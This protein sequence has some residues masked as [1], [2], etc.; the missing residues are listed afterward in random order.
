[1]KNKRG[2]L[3]LIAGLLILTACRGETA[4]RLWLKAPDWSRAQVVGGMAIPDPAPVVV[5]QAGNS[6][7][8]FINGELKAYE[9]QV[10]ALN[11][12]AE[13]VWEHTFDQVLK[14]PN[15]PQLVWDGAALHA[16]WINENALVTTQLDS[17]GNILQ[18]PTVISGDIPVNSYYV[19]SSGTGDVA[20]WFAKDRRVPG[21]YQA[22]V[23]LIEEPLLVDEQGVSPMLRF[24][25]AGTLHALWAHY[26]RDNPRTDFLYAAYPDGRYTPDSESLIYQTTI[27][28]TAEMFGP[29]LGLD[30]DTVY[31]Y[32]VEIFRTGLEAGFTQTR[33]LTFPRGAPQRITAPQETFIPS[34]HDLTY[35]PFSAGSLQAGSRFLLA[36]RPSPSTNIL[37]DIYTNPVPKDELV[38]AFRAG[39]DY[40][41]RGSAN[42]IGLVY[43]QDG[44]PTSYQ[45]LSFTQQASSDPTIISDSDGRLYVTWLEPGE[46]SR[47]DVYF[48]ATAGGIQDAFNPVTG[49]DVTD[50]LAATTFGLL[51]GILLTPIAAVLWLILPM[52]VIL[53]TSIFRRGEQTLQ[54]LGTIVSLILAVAIFQVSKFASLPGMTD[55]VPFSAWLPLPE[56][57]KFPLQIVVPI[58][59]LIGATF[60]AWHFTYRRSTASLLFFMIIYV[61]TDTLLTMAVY[62]VLFYGA[63]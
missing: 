9:A 7:F 60:T 36:A 5:D 33:L 12:S 11:S 34:E 53:L 50:L 21:L 57:V 26:P 22:D 51:T 6:Y 44:A 14:R 10:V 31:V 43:L 15:D 37:E 17:S 47:F 2:L 23:N 63:F 3:F 30:R 24:D 40:F 28:Q 16:F 48:A 52:A 25:E 8:L 58:A 59:I 13:R 46:V 41:W 29:T 4:E 20:V 18:E 62:G 49:R 54:S 35:E 27:P 45:L 61:A 55:Y 38:I 39:V 42:Q 1:M 19:A 32:W 56:V